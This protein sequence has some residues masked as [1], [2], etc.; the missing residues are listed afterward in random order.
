MSV[1]AV[2]QWWSRLCVS[3][4][5]LGKYLKELSNSSTE[6]TRCGC[7]LA[8]GALPQLFLAEHLSHI[9]TNLVAASK[10]TSKHASFVLSRRDCLTALNWYIDHRTEKFIAT[11]LVIR[12]ER[13]RSQLSSGSLWCEIPGLNLTVGSPVDHESH[14]DI[15][16]KLVM[17]SIPIP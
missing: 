2:C 7:A 4:R 14:S 13:N 1:S 11:L 16:Y 8:L 15:H 17:G 10:L 5:I 12:L 6:T 3:D 9:I